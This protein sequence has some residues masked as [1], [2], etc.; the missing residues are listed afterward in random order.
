LFRHVLF[1]AVLRA[2][3][4]YQRYEKKQFGLAG[5][6]GTFSKIP[7]VM[8]KAKPRDFGRPKGECA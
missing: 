2:Q 3:A 1:D 6:S 4:V 5:R 8:P 7:G